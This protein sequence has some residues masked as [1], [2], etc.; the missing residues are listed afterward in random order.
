MAWLL[1][2]A[3]LLLHSLRIGVPISKCL[4]KNKKRVLTIIL[5]SICFRMT[6]LISNDFFR[7][8]VFITTL[9]K[10]LQTIPTISTFP[11]SQ[12]IMCKWSWVDSSGRKTFDQSSEKYISIF[13]IY[14]QNANVTKIHNKKKKKCKNFSTSVFLLSSFFI[15]QFCHFTTKWHPQKFHQFLRAKKSTKIQLNW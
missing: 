8:E 13:W 11:S 1:P 4:P 3:Q 9:Y 2:L 7:K 15:F 12:K 14:I 10:R 5:H 6:I